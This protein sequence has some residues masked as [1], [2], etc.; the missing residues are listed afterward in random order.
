M[1]LREQV[2]VV[3]L[4]HLDGAEDHVA[5]LLGELL[6]LQVRVLLEH[7][8]DQVDAELQVQRLVADH[9]VHERAEVA[10]QVPLAEATA[11]P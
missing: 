6:G 7:R 5:D 4:L 11:P 10:Q 2:A 3:R 9:P 1:P 8:E